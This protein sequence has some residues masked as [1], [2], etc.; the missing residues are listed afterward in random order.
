MIVLKQHLKDIFLSKDLMI[1]RL[2]VIFSSFC[3]SVVVI[4]QSVLI[5][6]VNC[7]FAFGAHS[8]TCGAI[9]G[10][11]WAT[12]GI[13]GLVLRKRWKVVLVLGIL[14]IVVSLVAIL[15]TTNFKLLYNYAG[16]SAIYG[17]IY[18]V[19]AYNMYRMRPGQ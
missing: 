11:T 10:S 4:M 9:I 3:C 7:L 2:L 12:L 8:G 5:G 15:D 19:S 16:L 18:L 17:I 6:F 13:L 14:Y 1:Y